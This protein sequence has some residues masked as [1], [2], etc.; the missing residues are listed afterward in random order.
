MLGWGIAKVS[1]VLEEITDTKRER[2]RSERKCLKS[3]WAVFNRIF[4]NNNESRHTLKG[5]TFFFIIFAEKFI[6]QITWNVI[7]YHW[8]ASPAINYSKLYLKIILQIIVLFF[9]KIFPAPTILFVFLL[10]CSWWYFKRKQ[11]NSN[12]T[13]FIISRA[14]LFNLLKC[15]RIHPLQN[16]FLL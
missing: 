4:I 6:M 8:D 7:F 2:E 14:A 1:L 15:Q 16:Y 5:R 11:Q 3:S 9:L 10:I 13:Y 12:S